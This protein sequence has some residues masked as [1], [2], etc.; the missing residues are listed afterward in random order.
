MPVMRLSASQMKP[1]SSRASVVAEGTDRPDAD[2]RS[3]TGNAR[4][5]ARAW[6]GGIAC[7]G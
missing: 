2:R 4:P 3:L 1:I 5:A 6:Y 7:S